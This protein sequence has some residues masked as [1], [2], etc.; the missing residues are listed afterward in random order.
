MDMKKSLLSQTPKQLKTLGFLPLRMS[1][2]RRFA[3]DPYPYPAN[4]LSG[5]LLT[6]AN[7]TFYMLDFFQGF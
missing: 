2:N 4:P 6:L 5:S 7:T 1:D 3:G